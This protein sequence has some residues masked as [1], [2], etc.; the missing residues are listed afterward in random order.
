ML[1]QLSEALSQIQVDGFRFAKGF[2]KA[3]TA[4]SVKNWRTWINRHFA[5][6]CKA[7]F[8]ERHVRLWTWLEELT[9]GIKPFAR[10]EIWPRGSAKSTTAELGAAYVGQKG[11]RRFALYVSGTQDQ[12][13][14]HVSAIA[15]LF[16]IAGVARRINKYG[17]SRGWRRN[18]LQTANGFYIEA[19]GLDTAARGIK[20][21]EFRP[22][23]IIFDDIDEQ[24][25]SP[26]TVAK[27]EATI[28]S[29]II[30]AGSTDCAVLVIQNL[31]H[32]EGVVARLV[33][34]RSDFL[35]ARDAPIIE[36]AVEGLAVASEDCGNGLKRWRIVGGEATW[37][38]QS[39]DVC[40]R[41]INEI[42]LRTFLREAQ[43]EVIGAD[44]YFFDSTKFGI[45]PALP[46][47]L[48]GWK[49]CVAADFAATQCG[50]DYTAIVLMGLAPSGRSLIVRVWRDQLSPDNARKLLDS[51]LAWCHDT[52]GQCRLRLKQDPGQAGKDQALQLRARYRIWSPIIKPDTGSKAIRC[53]A[54]ADHVNSGNCDLLMDS[55]WNHAFKEEARKFREDESHE[56][57]DQVDAAA[58]AFNE[59]MKPVKLYAAI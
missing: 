52:V 55:D 37:E 10:I 47:D 21:D 51:A 7:P 28:A 17:S 57:D 33:D 59:L 41:Q 54:F 24:H 26:R 45:M 5:H 44:G 36:R 46:K 48:R 8:A 1:S 53:T 15:T 50:G 20:I 14:K 12:A 34:G 38:G 27:K 35:L 31:I 39:L 18:Q 9:P 56:Y 42:G 16:E 49:F 19:L 11:T 4:P 22:D 13:D 29:A 43:H 30:P 40:E 58:D 2:D 6:V 32:E 23:L 25:D 3:R